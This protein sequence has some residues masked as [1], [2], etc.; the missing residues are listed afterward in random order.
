MMPEGLYARW[1]GDGPPCPALR[2]LDLPPE[3]LLQAVWMHQRLLR[4]QLKTLDGRPVRILH[5]GFWNREAGPDFQ[6]AVIQFGD[7]KPISGDIE[8]DLEFG[9]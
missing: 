3:M 5:P 1:A 6:Q 7:D 2:E 9:G 4:D 8:V